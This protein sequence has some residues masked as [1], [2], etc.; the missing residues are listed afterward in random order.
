MFV[1]GDV[2]GDRQIT[3]SDVTLLS[4]LLFGGAGLWPDNRDAADTN[5][6]GQL[7]FGDLMRL[8]SHLQNPDDPGEMLA[9]PFPVP[10]SDPTEDSI[11]E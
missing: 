7:N 9:A 2:D 11:C 3:D 8:L 1:R 10:G 4:S 5:D 6:D